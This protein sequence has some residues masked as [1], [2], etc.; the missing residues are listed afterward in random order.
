MQHL[1]RRAC[2]VPL[3]ANEKKPA[4]MAGFFSTTRPDMCHFPPVG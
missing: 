2:A 4:E 3:Y 1:L